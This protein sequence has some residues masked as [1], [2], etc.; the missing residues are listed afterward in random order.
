MSCG[1][2]LALVCASGVIVRGGAFATRPTDRV[3]GYVNNAAAQ[4]A[5][6]TVLQGV[7]T[8]EQ[9]TRGRKSYER[10]CEKCHRA[11][12]SGDGALQGDGSEVVPILVGQSFALRWDGLTIADLFLTISN[13]MPWD[14]PGTLDPQANIDVVSYLLEK[15]DIPSGKAELPADTEKLASILITAKP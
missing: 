15:N 1:G 13:A 6:T 5:T 7:Y 3:R 8:A 14:A 2:I 12:L 11:D 9:A 10:R 4:E